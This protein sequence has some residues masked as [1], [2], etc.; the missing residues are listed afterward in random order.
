MTNQKQLNKIID[1]VISTQINHRK[2]LGSSIKVN[3][4][5]NN[6]YYNSNYNYVVNSNSASQTTTTLENDENK[7]STKQDENYVTGF[8]SKREN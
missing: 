7:S 5:I 2:S 6:N 4:N 1:N 3:L 8:L